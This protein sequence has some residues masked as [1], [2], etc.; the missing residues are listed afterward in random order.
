MTNG[1]CW[2]DLHG[3]P[4]VR[5]T[6]VAGA[7]GGVAGCHGA[8]DFLVLGEE[9]Q[10]LTA[11]DFLHACFAGARGDGRAEHFF[12]AARVAR[13]S[14]GDEALGDGAISGA[15]GGHVEFLAR[16][17]ALSARGRGDE[18]G[19]EKNSGSLETHVL[20]SRCFLGDY[21]DNFLTRSMT[22]RG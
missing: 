17:P 11:D 10:D 15:L 16:R 21:S 4:V 18:Q 6:G 5:E 7:I 9:G 12:Q 14:G 13:R 20:S 19:C 22:S 2:P 1:F 3:V 8:A